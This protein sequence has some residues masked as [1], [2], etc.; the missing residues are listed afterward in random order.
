MS[1][2]PKI[3][4]FVPEN[5][6]RNARY[7]PECRLILVSANDKAALSH[8]IESCVTLAQ[9]NPSDLPDIAY[10]CVEGRRA[11]GHRAAIVLPEPDEPADLNDDPGAESGEVQIA[12]GRFDGTAVS[13]AFMFP[14]QGSQYLGMGRQLYEHQPEFREWFRQCDSILAH[15][16]DFRLSELLYESSPLDADRS[17]TRLTQT[18]IAQPALFTIEYALGRL[19]MSYGLNPASLLG[20]SIGEFAA[21]TLAGVFELEAALELVTARGRLMQS[22]PPGSMM[23]VTADLDEIQDYCVDGLDV[24]ALNAPGTVVVSG[25]GERIA[26]FAALAENRGL[27]TRRLHTSHAFHSAMMDPILEKFAAVVESA[28]PRAPALPIVSTMT[29]TWLRDDEA[30]SAEYWAKQ[31]RNT[32]R[33]ADAVSTV[34]SAGDTVL[35]EV[36]PGVALTASAAAQQS[37]ED[38]P[39]TV[40]DTLGHPKADQPALDS[41]L[42]SVGKLWIHGVE[43][44]F[45]SLYDAP[46]RRLLRLPTYQFTRS[47]HWIEPPGRSSAHAP[48]NSAAAAQPRAKASAATP[49]SESS[50]D[51][52][53]SVLSAIQSLL[54]SRL[55]VEL[56]PSDLDKAFLALGFDSLGL[57]QLAGRIQQKFGIKVAVRRLF[58]DVDTPVALAE[59]LVEEGAVVAVSAPESIAVP[60]PAA[61]PGEADEHGRVAGSEALQALLSR[62]ERLESALNRLDTTIK[63]RL[64]GESSGLE[65]QSNPD[66]SDPHA[67]TQGQR[68]IWVAA[69]VGGDTANLAY[70]ECRAFTFD[71]VVDEPALFEALAALP[72][73][74]EALR[75]TFAADGERVIEAVTVAV[76]IDRHDLRDLDD[77]SRRE[78]VEELRRNQVSTPFDLV[79]G[80]LLRGDYVRIRD[81]LSVLIL[82]AHHIAVDGS[83]WELLIRE[84]AEMYSGSTEHREPA[85]PTPDSFAAYSAN[86]RDYV[87]TSGATEDENYWL[88]QLSGYNGALS[89]PEDSPR[90]VSRTLQSTRSDHSLPQVLMDRVRSVAAQLSCTPQTLLFGAFQILLYRLSRQDDF[91]VGIPTSGQ[92]AAGF[93]A[94]V[95]NCVNVLPIRTAIDESASVSSHIAAL[96]GR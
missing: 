2:R 67:L 12:K 44:D 96:H 25:P 33:F 82:C 39:A 57:S 76:P 49:G 70:N 9:R 15:I 72:R 20:H 4:E 69:Q 40:I 47:R 7:K 86:E 56:E 52:G 23:A 53:S 87:S 92:A 26:K 1:S 79:R 90:P 35:V 91:V 28:A 73:R 59:H 75:H 94:L 16:L 22:M 62:M 54:E 93:E 8:R 34:C 51:E 85:L 42:R 77:E 74:H 41:V 88:E 61:Q 17:R 83:S 63:G 5:E 18:S 43:P 14:G 19:L 89:L 58:Q 80:P 10:S 24:A 68:E 32:V 65:T 38:R 31:L 13:A 64:G 50:R 81:D 6:I 66:N 48:R 21:A 71:G 60:D 30:T 37:G 36:G 45:G 46:S 3:A 95:G 84:L 27:N 55:G 29:G 11:F 78:A